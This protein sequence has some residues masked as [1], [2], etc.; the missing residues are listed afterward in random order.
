MRPFT[1]RYCRALRLRAFSG[2]DTKPLI[3]TSEVSTSTGSNCRLMLFFQMSAILCLNEPGRRSSVF[4]SRSID[5]LMLL[6][7]SASRSNS[8]MML[9]VS[10]L[11]LFRNFRLAGTLKKRFFTIMLEPGSHSDGSCISTLDAFITSRVPIW[12]SA[13]RVFSSICAMAQMEGRASPR[14]PIVCNVNRSSACAIFEVAW[15]SK[16]IRASVSVM[17]LPLSTTWI[18]VRPAS[19][20]NMRMSVA[21]ASTAFSTSSLITEAGR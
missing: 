14:N 1:I 8:L 13:V 19:R 21:P 17:P 20:M 10:T 3:L 6:F 15:R 4:P 12:S 2:R 9:A 7:T 16:A 5:S 11:S 18:S